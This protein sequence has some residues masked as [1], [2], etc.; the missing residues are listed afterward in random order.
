MATSL[1]F[2]M[3]LADKVSGPAG[4]ISKS[5]GGIEKAA[6]GI[7]AGPLE[8]LTSGKVKGSTRILK[9][10]DGVLSRAF[11]PKTMAK[12]QGAADGLGPY[13]DALY[14]ARHAILGVAAA[15]AVA[16]TGASAL[17]LAGTKF[18]VDAQS[19]KQ[20]TLTAFKLMLGS[21]QAADKFFGEAIKFAAETPFETGQV[22]GGFKSLLGGGFKPEEV[23]TVL[24]AVGD[25]AAIQNFDPEVI[26]RMILAINQMKG[27]GKMAA[28]EL[29]QIVEAS[30]GT[31]ARVKIYETLAKQ[32]GKTKEEIIKLAE[33][34]KISADQGIGAVLETI[35]TTISG[36][37]LGGL[38]KELSTQIPG[39][40]STL[41]G[42]PE[43]LIFAIPEDKLKGLEMIRS[44]LSDL[45]D[46]LDPA[47]ES[48][49]KLADALGGAFDAFTK[50][51]LGTSAE[52]NKKALSGGIEG[53]T[54]A[55]KNAQP[56]LQE[57]GASIRDIGRLAGWFV[58]AGNYVTDLG[59]ALSNTGSVGS[60]A[61]SGLGTII[62]TLINP[63]GTIIGLV[64]DVVDRFRELF[65]IISGDKPLVLG[66]WG[67]AISA[68][69]NSIDTS[70]IGT[71]IINGIVNGIT[72]GASSVANAINSA[73]QGAIDAAKNTLGIASPSK[74]FEELGA[75]SMAGYA[76]GVSNDNSVAPAVGGMLAAP[77]A[78]SGGA[79]GSM[80]N[81]VINVN[82]TAGKNAEETGAVVGRTV[83][84]EMLAL[85]QEVA[86]S[87]GAAA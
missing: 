14:E 64:M 77:A 47:S 26:H 44:F 12:I 79:G 21:Q 53:M 70:S 31:V 39:L 68:W 4:K 63:L 59:K 34:G 10:L 43:E 5:L 19:F 67:E 22:I 28:E 15:G 78:A 87:R 62:Q 7:K 50:G 45:N 66:P 72:S 84:R 23:K 54:E 81:V 76:R 13:A 3:S 33:T 69:L 1:E 20:S 73:T 71:N 32:L 11:S 60:G 8:S 51:L 24:S 30:G 82:V 36:G 42:R 2:V 80:G 75:Y 17:A 48:G 41:K 52:E 9:D 49:K 25:V 18:V 55:I 29:N 38:M 61:W 35:R 40:M 37:K 6:K 16:F 58:T 74:V 46:L 83:R 85:M 57:L 56:A 27:K 65:A 86:L